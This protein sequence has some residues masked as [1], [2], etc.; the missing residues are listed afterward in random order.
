MDLNAKKGNVMSNITLIKDHKF[1][2]IVISVRF[3]STLKEE[4]IASKM[5]LA[6]VLNDVCEPYDTKQ[7]VSERLDAMYGS[8]FSITS[9]VVG[10]AQIMVAKVKSIHPKFIRH[11]KHLLA[12]QFALLQAFLLQPLQVNNSFLEAHVEEAKKAQEAYMKRVIDDPNS[13]SMQEVM[14]IAGANQPL[15][16]GASTTIEDVK[17]VSVEMVNAQYAKI[18]KDKVDILVFGDVEEDEVNVLAQQYLQPLLTN[19]EH[20][21]INYCLKHETLEPIIYGY[22]DISQSYIASLYTT[23]IANDSELFPALRVA[24]AIFGQLPSGLLF[25]NIREKNSLCYSIYSMINPYDGT[26]SISTGVDAENVQK[27][28]ALIDEQ[29]KVML[30]GSFSDELLTT[31]KKMIINSQLSSND[32]MDA[33]LALAYRNVL[34]HTSQSLEQMIAE[35]EKV[36]KE[37]V[38]KAMNCCRYVTSY[39]LTQKG[40]KYE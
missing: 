10:N 3:L 15:G 8:S 38:V 21:K 34:L 2:N 28:L 13:F 27:T 25:Q 36:S 11:D 1:K 16:I 22:R 26:L 4:D 39:V 14:R 40:E 35:I 31:A 6:N 7:K 20:E 19:S 32:D 5:V 33:I 18:L 17:K 23:N 37:D 30:Q 24:N 12:E 9:S 29:F